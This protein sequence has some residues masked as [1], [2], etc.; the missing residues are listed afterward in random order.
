M[1]QLIFDRSLIARRKQRAAP[2]ALEADFLLR[3]AAQELEERMGAILRDFDM[4]VDLS[5]PS[6][7]V[8][9]AL[10]AS[11]KVKQV[12]RL[13]RTISHL[14]GDALAAVADEEFLPLRDGAVDLIVSCLSL[15]LVNDLP[16]TLAQIRRALRP[17]GLFIGAV[18][19]GA[20]LTELRQS[21]AEAESEI[22]GGASP[23][24]APFTDVRELGSLLQRAGL[25]LPVS[26]MDRVTVRY[27]DVFALM[28]DLRD[29]G[30]TNAMIERRKTPLRRATLLRMAE[31]YQQRFAQADGR[32]PATFEIIWMAGWAPH[33]SQQKPLKPGSAKARLADAL[34]AADFELNK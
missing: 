8:A 23:R 26:D 18:L 27:D 14:E 6:K 16:G 29:M 30:A 1:T 7:L 21:F 3:R 12:L 24:V 25:A 19:G 33:D 13:D 28:R 5:S 34:N 22:E 11:G 10:L 2:R 31:I 15:Q 20:T 9:D 17:D 4:A 32:I